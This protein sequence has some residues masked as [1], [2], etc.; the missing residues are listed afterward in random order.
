MA[1]NSTYGAMINQKPA[2]KSV[3]KD[4]PKGSAWLK[5][6]TGCKGEK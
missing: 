2:S 6:L 1:T 3:L 4:A 5:M